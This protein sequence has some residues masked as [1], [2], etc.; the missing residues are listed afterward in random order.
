MVRKQNKTTTT[1]TK[2]LCL[3][4]LKSVRLQAP[5]RYDWD[6]ELSFSDKE[7]LWVVV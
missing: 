7:Q 4:S 2:P 1:T 3:L 5:H 6:S